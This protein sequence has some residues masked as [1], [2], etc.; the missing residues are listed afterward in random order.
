M[1]FVS[2]DIHLEFFK[3]YQVDVFIKKIDTALKTFD[4]CGSKILILAGDICSAKSDNLEYFLENIHTKF[5][6]I[7]YVP[8]NHE[9]YNVSIEQGNKLLNEVTGKFN[10]VILL[11]NGT[12]YDDENDILFIGTTLWSNLAH[13]GYDITLAKY[14]INDFRY[15]EE[16]KPQNYLDMFNKNLQFITNILENNK[17]KQK[18]I[19]THHMPSYDLVAE[20]FKGE[21]NICFASELDHMFDTSIKAW[22]YGHTHCPSDK[23][24]G[25]TRFKCNP[26]GYKGENQ[27]FKVIDTLDL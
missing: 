8:G 1:Y 18:I 21:I 26:I 14:M 11:N 16:F 6:K 2:S 12:Y 24:I 7:I 19:V 25:E 9:Y 13:K 20:E 23:V 4:D 5:T 17:D 3:K 22:I 15:I 10:N 27:T